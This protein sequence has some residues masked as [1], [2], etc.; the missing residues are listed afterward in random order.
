MSGIFDYIMKNM[1]VLVQEILEKQFSINPSLEKKYTSY[2]INICKRDIKH[3]LTHLAETI[4][5]S[6]IKLFID[7]ISWAKI[8]LDNLNISSQELIENLECVTFILKKHF[9]KDEFKIIEVFLKS[10]L[11][12]VKKEKDL[13][14][15]DITLT[16]EAQKYLN[17]LLDGN[18]GEAS[19]LIMKYIE[20]GKDIKEIYLEIFQATQI[21]VGKM[22]QENKIN[23]AQEHYVTA[24]TQMIMS[25]LYN[26]VLNTIKNNYTIIAASVSHELHEI[27]IRIVSDFLELE[28]FNVYYLGANMPLKDI[29][30]SIK[31]K[32]A[33]IL[34]L[35]AT[36]TEHIEEASKIINEIKI[37]ESTK[38]IKI[39]VGGYPFNVDQN[40]W[41][42][43]K[44]DGYSKD[45]LN[46]VEVVK[47]L[48]NI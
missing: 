28:G 44:A 14:N 26:Y 37:N 1:D 39:M 32:K 34:M 25:Q 38:H 46:T 2:Q 21:E 7:Y 29:M 48:L 4:K 3:T 19:N 47:K 24:S 17:F 16:N 13:K 40:L 15:S 11:E 8:L 31:Q 45:A 9:S 18:K 6:S 20:K 41:K 22:W 30:K 42:T 35:S 33:N 27:G 12:E 5:F 36:M 23:V 43:L 10:A